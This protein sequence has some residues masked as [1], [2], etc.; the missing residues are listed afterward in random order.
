MNTSDWCWWCWWRLMNH[1]PAG[2]AG[3]PICAGLPY[4]SG[5]HQWLPGGGQ[6]HRD[7]LPLL[8]APCS[9]EQ[10]Q[11]G[12]QNSSSVVFNRFLQLHP[13]F[14]LKLLLK[15]KN[16]TVCYTDSVWS[17]WPIWPCGAAEGAS[18]QFDALLID[19]CQIPNKIKLSCLGTV[20]S[21]NW[22]HPSWVLIFQC[23][24]VRCRSVVFR[25]CSW[26]LWNLKRNILH[27]DTVCV[28]LG[29]KWCNHSCETAQLFWWSGCRGNGMRSSCRLPAGVSTSWSKQTGEKLCVTDR[30]GRAV[31][32]SSLSI[33][34]F[35]DIC[36]WSS[37]V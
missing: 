14:Y 6:Q 4:S 17:V 10:V 8:S 11:P 37:L 9:H 36:M 7:A 28:F 27:S 16:F 33:Y 2:P 12:G 20:N 13:V 18:Y 34:P 26:C 5:Q 15:L 32:M 24:T 23:V 25:W 29:K 22:L 30:K 3:I 21:H 31:L 35:F 19:Q 1:S